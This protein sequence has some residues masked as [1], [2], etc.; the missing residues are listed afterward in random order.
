MQFCGAVISSHEVMKP[1]SFEC[2][3]T[4]ERLKHVISGFLVMS[5]I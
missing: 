5:L 1:Q 4:Q 3:M 2:S